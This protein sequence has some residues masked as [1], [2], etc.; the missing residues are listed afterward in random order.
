MRTAA[1]LFDGF[2]SCWDE[3]YRSELVRPETIINEHI[4]ENWLPLLQTPPFPE[5]TS[6]H[7]VIS[8]AAGIMLTG[9]FGDNFAFQDSTERIYGLPDRTFESFN[10]ASD[11]AAISR[12]YGGI[13]Y[14][15]AIE[16]GVLQ[17]RSLGR[18]LDSTLVTYK[19]R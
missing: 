18:H 14:M 8:G 10:A 3:K 17:G 19:H 5:Y 7:S 6:G 4:D 15:P 11:E 9:M 16:N 13:H 2:I 12:L 1:G